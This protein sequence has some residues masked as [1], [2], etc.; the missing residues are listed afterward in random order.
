[1]T[2]YRKAKWVASVGMHSLNRS[3][4]G[5]VILLSGDNFPRSTDTP[6]R[7]RSEL[8]VSS[9]VKYPTADPSQK[10]SESSLTM[11]LMC[12][13]ALSRTCSR[14]CSSCS[15]LLLLPARI[16]AAGSLAI[17]A[18]VRSATEVQE[19]SNLPRRPARLVDMRTPAGG[20]SFRRLG[21]SPS[22]Y[23]SFGRFGSFTNSHTL[24]F[25]LNKSFVPT[26]PKFHFVISSIWHP[27]FAKLLGE[28]KFRSPFAIDRIC[29][30][31]GEP[32]R[33]CG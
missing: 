33:T 22:H 30:R 25:G 10:S 23:S 9:S 26:P 7:L 24:H 8:K 17:E 5:M 20:W 11:T 18:Q 1:M 19:R 12:R 4:S 32:R 28:I 31:A 16:A 15:V 27:N 14:N 2:G 21:T 3:P 6:L 29:R 13:S